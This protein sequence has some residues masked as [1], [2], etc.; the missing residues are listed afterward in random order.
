MF[1]LLSLFWT[2][3]HPNN[4]IATTNNAPNNS[5]RPPL[6]SPPQPNLASI[7][8]PAILKRRHTTPQP[9]RQ[10]SHHLRHPPSQPAT[11][12]PVDAE[13]RTRSAIIAERVEP[14]VR[15]AAF[16]REETDRG[17]FTPPFPPSN[18]RAWGDVAP[19]PR[20]VCEFRLGKI[21]DQN[22]LTPPF[23]PTNG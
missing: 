3:H 13:R 20:R 15:I 1:L 22:R 21:T 7:A 5:T 14:R 18:G 12:Q 4:Q 16:P 8:S 9:P 23:C 2:K 11:T 10:T 19:P 17:S 6:P